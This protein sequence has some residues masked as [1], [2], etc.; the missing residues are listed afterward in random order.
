[1]LIYISSVFFFG[2]LAAPWIHQLTQWIAG[3]I[4]AFQELAQA[5]FHRYVNRSL[6][7][8]AVLGMW[9]FLVSLRAVSWKTVGLEKPNGQWGRVG[10][11]FGLGFLTLAV[12]GAIAV[13]AQSRKWDPALG[14][15]I[16][17]ELVGITC[18]SV[19]VALLEELLFRGVLFGALCRAHTWKVA[20][21]LS[22]AFYA[23][24]HFFKRVKAPPDIT[25]TS[26]FEQLA[27]MLGGFVDPLALIP[28]F[29]SLT[30]AGMALGLAYRRTGN[31]FFP[32]G[33]HAG[34]VFWLKTFNELTVAGP[35]AQGLLRISKILYDGWLGLAVSVGALAAVCFLTQA[36]PKANPV[37]DR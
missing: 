21:I 31:L 7:F 6:L 5:P 1:L 19:V 23:A 28:G 24:M 32:L 37:H 29:L 27:R 4:P 35:E 26:G 25:W 13:L 12:A 10:A 3:H 8:F 15:A 9:P 18:S 30:V 17:G 22:S 20:L 33:L 36:K 11:G 16:L 2:A 14:L 34:W